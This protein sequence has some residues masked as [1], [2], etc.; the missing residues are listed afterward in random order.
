MFYF[1]EE[2]NFNSDEGRERHIGD[3][4]FLNETRLNGKTEFD[5]LINL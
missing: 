2:I 3:E 1:G 5:N 4:Y